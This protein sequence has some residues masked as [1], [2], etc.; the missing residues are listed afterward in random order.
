MPSEIQTDIVLGDL[1]EIGQH[2]L[3]CGDSTDSEQVARL[4]DGEKADIIFTDPPY[5][6]NANNKSGVLKKKYR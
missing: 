1:I 4:M 6:M 5:G 2:R 3:L